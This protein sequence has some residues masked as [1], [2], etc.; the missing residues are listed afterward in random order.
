MMKSPSEAEISRLDRR[1]NASPA[2]KKTTV[3]YGGDSVLRQEEMGAHALAA[4]RGVE[5]DGVL[6]QTS[7]SSVASTTALSGVR[8]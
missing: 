1:R 4:I 8:S 5:G 3:W 7:V 6:R 2:G